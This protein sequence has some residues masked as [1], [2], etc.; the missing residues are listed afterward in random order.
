M[1]AKRA[2]ACTT[3]RWPTEVA[4]TSAF[5]LA[6]EGG[7]MRLRETTGG[8]ATMIVTAPDGRSIQV[9]DLGGDGPPCLFH[10]GTPG[11]AYVN[12]VL[13][14]AARRVGLRVVTYAR[15]GYG[16]ST[17][18]PGRTVAQCASDSVV[19]LDALGLDAFVVYGGSGGGPHALACAALLPGR[20]LAAAAVASIAPP[21]AE[22][23]EF[24]AGM[25]ED[26]VMELGLALQGRE[27]LEPYLREDAEG[28]DGSVT[29]EQ[30]V[31]ALSTVLCEADR[32]ALTAERAD[33]MLA[34]MREALRTGVEGWLG[35]DLALTRTWGFDVSAITVPVALWQGAQDLMVPIAHGR[36]LASRIPTVMPHLYEEHGHVSLWLG[37]QDS[38]LQDLCELAQVR[39]G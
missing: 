32:A 28:M 10:N 25:G 37:Q 13:A 4:L 14:D 35:D 31:A 5:T 1:V 27:A 21:D 34:G 22:G 26:N 33:A 17:P 29:G 11:G 18:L 16:D 24:L 19:V 39:P 2:A 7:Y 12:P 9:L 6:A 30:L 23:L 8:R 15:P 38:I 36:W 20:C 3:S